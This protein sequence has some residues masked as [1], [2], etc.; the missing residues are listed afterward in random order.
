MQLCG[1]CLCC[2]GEVIYLLEMVTK[3]DN[4]RCKYIGVCS[5]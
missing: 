3:D 1:A 4:K 5:H 2:N